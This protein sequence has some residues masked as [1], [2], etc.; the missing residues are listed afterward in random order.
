MKIKHCSEDIH[1]LE[2]PIAVVVRD[3]AK[4][5]Q[6][7]NDHLLA[8]WAEDPI[9]SKVCDVQS[10]CSPQFTLCDSTTSTHSFSNGSRRV[11]L[12]VL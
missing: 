8:E 12:S 3:T 2:R 6:P 7:T 9:H 4:R 1:E 11:S 5:L 10:K